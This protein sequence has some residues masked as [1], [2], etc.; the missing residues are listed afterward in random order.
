M[1]YP[2]PFPAVR[3]SRVFNSPSQQKGFIST[4]EVIVPK[5]KQRFVEEY[6]NLYTS[7][8]IVLIYVVTKNNCQ[9]MTMT[10]KLEDCQKSK[11]HFLLERRASSL[12][13][14]IAHNFSDTWSCMLF[15]PKITC[16]AAIITLKLPVLFY[17][18]KIECDC[19]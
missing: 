7:E 9:S 11:R 15:V 16:A 18:W 19:Q 5:H 8:Y 10:R 4:L 2:Y 14:S 13:N 6:T 12:K 17:H 3:S 1:S